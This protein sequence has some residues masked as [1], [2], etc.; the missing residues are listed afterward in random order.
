MKA[1]L[2]KRSCM[3]SWTTS[4]TRLLVE[5]MLKRMLFYNENGCIWYRFQGFGIGWAAGDGLCE[6]KPG[7]PSARHNWFQPSP[8]D[9]SQ[10]TY[11]PLSQDGSALRKVLL[12]KDKTQEQAWRCSSCQMGRTHSNSQALEQVAERHNRNFNLGD[13]KTWLRVVLWNLL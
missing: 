3:S 4:L 1:A 13:T 9:P 11:E 7:L 10:A 6:E 2:Q 8:V 5:P 12:R